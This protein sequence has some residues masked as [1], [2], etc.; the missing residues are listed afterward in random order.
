MNC[1]LIYCVNLDSFCLLCMFCY[2]FWK[3]ELMK[4]RGIQI[5]I[6]VSVGQRLKPHGYHSYIVGNK[7]TLATKKI[8][9]ANAM[10]ITYHR[11]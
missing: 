2:L 8:K 9:L 11:V 6:L 4:I 3:R 10:F 5:R 7:V 1:R